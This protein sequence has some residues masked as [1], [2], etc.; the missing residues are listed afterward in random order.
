MEQQIEETN[1]Q[2]TIES[3]VASW[4]KIE[5]ELR[6][7]AEKS[8]TLTIIG[9]V[10]GPKAGYKVVRECRLYLKSQRVAIE[11]KRKGLKSGILEV[12]KMI[13]NEAKRL[14][15][16]IEPEE[17]RL[18]SMEKEYDLEQERIKREAEEAKKRKINAR[19]AEMQSVGA[20]F[21]IDYIQNA[22]DE[23]FSAHIETKREE[24]RIADELA[25]ENARKEA[26]RIE[27][28]NRIKEEERIKEFERQEAIR[29]EN[30]RIQ[31]EQEAE[32]RRIQKEKDDLEAERK[33]IESEQAAER[34]RIQDEKDALEAQRIAIEQQHKEQEPAT[35]IE[36][37]PQ[38]QPVQIESVNELL[39]ESVEQTFANIQ[40]Q[41]EKKI[42]DGFYW[43]EDRI[44]GL[45][46]AELRDN[47]WMFIGSEEVEFNI[48]A[49]IIISPIAKPEI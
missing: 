25:A 38:A 40:D 11:N 28:Q 46:I 21:D 48:S 2:E 17:S 7:M 3:Q 31:D 27:E 36:P 9:N 44:D 19:I 39:S 23:E 4:R 43:I 22:N 47:V 32:A 37:E 42:K 34:K 30:K 20:F 35:Q 18:E 49:V 29:K 15:A 26:E 12:G 1:K 10:D 45:S 5:S 24:K 13:D 33:R 41:S 8:S 6:E 14:T 16:I